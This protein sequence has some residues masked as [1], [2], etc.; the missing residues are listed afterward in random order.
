MTSSIA[1]IHAAAKRLGLDEDTRRAKMMLIVG[2]SSTKAMT[3]DE[4]QKVLQVLNGDGYKPSSKPRPDGRKKLSGQY[5]GKLQAMWIAGWNLGVIRDRDDSALIAF[6]KR[7]TGLD[8]VQFLRF[9]DDAKKAI[10]A[11]KAMLHREGAVDWGKS[12]FLPEY[13]QID[14]YRIAKAQWKKL[15]EKGDVTR[16]AMEAAGKGIVALDN[17]DWITVMNLLGTRVRGQGIT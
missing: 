11:I 7:Q 16:F 12:R 9:P 8:A 5:A 3:E 1:S 6:V 14:G 13:T 17:K 4:R 2:K 10:E 15:G